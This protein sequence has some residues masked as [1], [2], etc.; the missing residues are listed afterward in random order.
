MVNGKGDE[1][2]K[3]GDKPEDEVDPLMLGQMSNGEKTDGVATPTNRNTILC[4][5]GL[6]RIFDGKSKNLN[7]FIEAV[8]CLAERC[9]ESEKETLLVNVRMKIQKGKPGKN[10][11]ALVVGQS[12]TDDSPAKPD[13]QTPRAEAN[14]S[15]TGE[16]IKEF[17]VLMTGYQSCSSGDESSYRRPG[18]YDASGSSDDKPEPELKVSRGWSGGHVPRGIYNIR[19]AA[20]YAR[21]RERERAESVSVPARMP[22]TARE[23]NEVATENVP[24]LCESVPEN[25]INVEER[26]EEIIIPVDPSSWTIRE[27]AKFT[28]SDGSEDEPPLITQV[29]VHGVP[30]KGNK[31]FTVA[32][33]ATGNGK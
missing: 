29:T 14:E 28:P 17:Q 4:N 8:E 18:E 16:L 6:I 27:E 20:A 15:P 33:K 30:G 2:R 12:L 23:S 32:I 9:P 5:L 31:P 11:T 21:A 1:V 7:D 25:E 3:P 10:A 19:A 22:E 26:V 24:I 13:V